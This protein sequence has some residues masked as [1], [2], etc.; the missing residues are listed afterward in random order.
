MQ[1]APFKAWGQK[2]T[3]LPTLLTYYGFNIADKCST[4][5]NQLVYKGKQDRG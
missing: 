1:A 3:L 2:N 5:A 4:V